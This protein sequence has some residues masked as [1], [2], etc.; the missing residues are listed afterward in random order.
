MFAV[1]ENNK[2]PLR[3]SR[4]HNLIWHTAS[5]LQQSGT[6]K[7]T[8][9]SAL[10]FL[11]GAANNTQVDWDGVAQVMGLKNGSVATVRF[12]QIKTKLGWSTGQGKAS[13]T[14]NSRGPSTGRVSKSRASPAKPC[15]PAKPRATGIDRGRGRPLENVAAVELK[16]KFMPDEDDEE[17]IS[18]LDNVKNEEDEQDEVEIEENVF[19]GNLLDSGEDDEDRMS[20]GTLEEFRRLRRDR[21]LQEQIQA[22]A[23]DDGDFDKYEDIFADADESEQTEAV[24]MWARQSGRQYS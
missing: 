10:H 7:A 8:Y 23:G 20:E 16:T 14:N 12:G 18:E 13:N 2:S 17:D 4:H 9:S 24:P 22:E 21:E 15:A 19:I 5:S 11:R 6:C 1:M 3:V